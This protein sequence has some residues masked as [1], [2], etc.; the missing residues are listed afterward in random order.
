MN[1]EREHKIEAAFTLMEL[2][3]VVTVIA[4]LAIILLPAAS[5]AKDSARSVSCDNNLRQLGQALYLHVS[6]YGAYPLYA[7]ATANPANLPN[8]LWD[9]TLLAYCSGNRKLLECP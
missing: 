4:L 3:V 7:D 1:S 2:L 9:S 6:D 8:G 5:R